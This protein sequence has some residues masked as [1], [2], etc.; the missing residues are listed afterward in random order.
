MVTNS[1]IDSLRM[2]GMLLAL[3]TTFDPAVAGDLAVEVE[4]RIDD[5]RVTVTVDNGRLTMRRGPAPRPDATVTGDVA[6]VRALVY[7][8]TADMPGPGVTIYGDRA[9]VRRLLRA[10]R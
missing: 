2:A 5:D 1:T 6:A 8:R 10:L 4:L 9:A 7:R 3:R